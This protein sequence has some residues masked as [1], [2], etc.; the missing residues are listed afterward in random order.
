[1]GYLN[2]F[3]HVEAD[4][5][6]L[7]WI[8]EQYSTFNARIKEIEEHFDES[9]EEITTK[10]EKLSDDFE[11]LKTEVN[12]VIDEFED[13]IQ[14]QLENGLELIESQIENISNNMAIY[15]NEHMSEWQAEATYNDSQKRVNFNTSANPILDVNKSVYSFLIGSTIHETKLNPP[16]YYVNEVNPTISSNYISGCDITLTPGTH[17]V[18]ARVDFTETAI[19]DGHSTIILEAGS[20]VVG[21]IP[22]S[23][24]YHV[25]ESENPIP[26]SLNIIGLYTNTNTTTN[27][28]VKIKVN[29]GANMSID[30]VKAC[31]YKI[32]DIW[33]PTT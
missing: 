30:G 9:V 6:N 10:F 12:E 4:K 13:S 1:M 27:K 23:T 7:D 2:E 5:L 21:V 14:E 24:M 11:D 17:I 26:Y 25:K 15:V 33:D 18:F 22:G 8:L 29:L 32:S 28:V 31:A 19:V 3:P 16:L 20:D